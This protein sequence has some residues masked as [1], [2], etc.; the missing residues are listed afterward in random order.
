[1]SILSELNA[2]MSEL[3]LPVETG[4]FSGA[5]PKEYAVLTPLSDLFAVHADNR[6]RCEILS[7]RISLFSKG[8]YTARARKVAAALIDADFVITERRFV[9]FDGDAGYFHYNIDI[10]KEYPYP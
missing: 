7:V 8:S 2:I 10:E 1:V 4:V 6:P 3:N 5:A 9:G